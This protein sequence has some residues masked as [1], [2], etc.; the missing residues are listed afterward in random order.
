MT[1]GPDT[2]LPAPAALP[3]AAPFPAA[4]P[5][6][7]SLERRQWLGMGLLTLVGLVLVSLG[8]Y[9]LTASHLAQRRQESLQA[10]S[11]LVVH[12]LTERAASLVR[13]TRG[14]PVDG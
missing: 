11:R 14:M 8:V 10:M 2:H 5:A 7:W 4:A 9:G 6:A 12:L 1:A 13:D 3:D